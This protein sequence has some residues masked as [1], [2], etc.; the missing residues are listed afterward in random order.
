MPTIGKRIRKRR[1]ELGMTQ[2]ELASKLH[3]KSKTT[4]AKIENGTN[5]IVQSKVIEFAKALHTTPAYLMGW[6]QVPNP[7]DAKYTLTASIKAQSKD[8][9]VLKIAQMF[10]T[11]NDQNDLASTLTLEEAKQYL[12]DIGKDNIISSSDPRY[13][14]KTL[15]EI[16]NLLHTQE[17]IQYYTTQI[18]EDIKA[19]PEKYYRF[20]SYYNR[21][22]QLGR[23]TATEQVRLLTLDK[24]YTE[25]LPDDSVRNN[26]VE[27]P[28]HL[29]PR[30]AHNDFADNEEQQRLMNEDLD[31]L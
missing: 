31:D 19:D 7:S 27:L 5:D 23:S 9:A 1:E 30:A 6:S 18:I 14:N 21:L 4:I 25:N 24:K 12:K 10:L 15:D 13:R 29:E 22:N 28:P 16:A 8:E 26:I 17:I 3:Y 11:Q 20:L 2:E